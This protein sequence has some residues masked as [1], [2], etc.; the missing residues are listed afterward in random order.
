M[1]ELVLPRVKSL[2][3]IVELFLT[4][5]IAARG[6]LPYGIRAV[7]SKVYEMAQD[8]FPKA[9][10]VAMGIRNC[11][12]TL[13]SI[14]SGV[15]PTKVVNAVSTIGRKRATPASRTASTTPCPR[16]RVPFT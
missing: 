2:L 10:D 16:A 9:S 4:R 14:R 8:R 13:R 7:A 3:E 1:R 11:A 6:N 5:V 12:C 15:S